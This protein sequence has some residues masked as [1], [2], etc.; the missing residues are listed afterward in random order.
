[1]IGPGFPSS[2]PIDNIVSLVGQPNETDALVEGI[3][4]RALVDSGSQITT[5][6]DHFYRE[7]LEDVPLQTL[8]SILEIKGAGGHTLNYLGYVSINIAFPEGVN[9]DVKEHVALVLV[10][11]DTE[12]NTR[13]PL[14]IGT[15]LIRPYFE[16]NLATGGKDVKTWPV[17]EAWRN[18]YQSLVHVVE[19]VDGQVIF[20]ENVVKIPAHSKVFVTGLVHTPAL[21]NSCTVSVEDADI[22]VPG[23]LIVSACINC[24]S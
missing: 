15:N 11:P 6:A 16:E 3:S 23:G 24:E 2:G 1:V 19:S 10:V 21:P 4:C 8:D 20:T 14:I 5:I 12:Y 9:G 22:S 17:T 18:I 7:Y 13:V